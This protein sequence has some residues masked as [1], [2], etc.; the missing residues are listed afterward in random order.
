M[1]SHFDEEARYGLALC[2][3]PNVG[4]AL[5]KQLLSYCGSASQ[6]FRMPKARLQKV[7]GIGPVTADQILRADVLREA[8]AELEFLHRIGAEALFYHDPRYPQR[9]LHCADA[10][11]VL[12]AKGRYDLNAARMISIIGTRHATPYGR[13]ITE[14]L[15]ETL[16]AY[17]FTLVS[18]LA[19]GID[20]AAHR[21]AGK[22]QLQNIA[23]L[24]HGL[25]RIYPWQH[26]YVAE[27]LQE[28]GALLTDF[29]SGTQPDRQ[30]FPKRNRIV[31][32]MTDATIVVESAESGGALITAEIANSYDR[33][34][35]AVPGKIGDEFSKGCNTL[36][37]QNKAQL[38]TCAGDIVQALRWDLE[39]ATSRPVAAPSLFPELSPVEQQVYDLIREKG[40]ISLEWLIRLLPLRA[41]ELAAV[42]LQLEMQ[43]LVHARPGNIYALS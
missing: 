33:E 18:G 17:G 3:V 15:V 37:R 2:R 34:V 36:I 10:P 5:A 11:F 22:H 26:R 6:V 12:F 35:F 39:S 40:K 23:V 13:G 24:A 38:V 29:M 1:R 20:I 16:S 25:D 30:N 14:M 27:Q 8:D 42:L 9:L 28:N 19:F 32:G 7:P 4:D 31:A 41:G 43:G 21:A